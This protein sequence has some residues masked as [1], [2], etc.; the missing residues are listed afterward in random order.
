M[1]SQPLDPISTRPVR[2]WPLFVVAG[3]V[4][5]ILLGG[6]GFVV[7]SALEE[8]D[9]F[10]IACHTVPETHYFNR[11]Y[12]ALDNPSEPIT[13]LSTAHY[14]AAQDKNLEPFTCIDCHRG[15]G[16]LGHRISTV[17]LGGRDAVIYVL[18]KEDPALEKTSTRE[19][20][21]P[22][23]AC[24]ACHTETLLTLEGLDNH[25]HTHLPQA[26]AALA[27]GGALKVPDT[28][29]AKR[30]ELLAIG[31]KTINTSLVCTDCHHAHVTQPDGAA[32][33]FM[34]TDRRNQSCVT[35]HQ[36]AKE[37]PQ[38]PNALSQGLK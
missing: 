32:A 4:G 21:L 23:A 20:W 25:F 8:H 14:R 7:V 16:S 34:Q 31:L 28:L 37:G 13:D 26:A 6:V 35:C 5:L 1:T 36:A 17:A 30:T 22:N 2:R 24:T 18:G 9:T 19:G 29:E 3:F 10:C 27:N 11:A 33:F 38:D 15:D 12:Y